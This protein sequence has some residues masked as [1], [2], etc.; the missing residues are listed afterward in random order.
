[1]DSHT[2]LLFNLQNLDLHQITS[3]QH[4]RHFL[5]ALAGYLRNVRKPTVKQTFLK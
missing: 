2:A 5:Y 1:M 3:L 4:V